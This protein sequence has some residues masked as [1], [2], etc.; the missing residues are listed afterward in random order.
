MCVCG[1]GGGGGDGGS[2]SV[3]LACSCPIREMAV[4]RLIWTLG[5]LDTKSE[6]KCHDEDFFSP[7]YIF[8][9]LWLFV[10]FCFL[11]VKIVGIRYFWEI[12]CF[13]SMM[14]S[15]CRCVSVSVYYD[16]CLYTD[17]VPV[18]IVHVVPLGMVIVWRH[19]HEIGE[20]R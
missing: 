1:G 2:F 18:V 7:G 9:F 5:H 16:G 12:C 13:G 19:G 20:D 4:I 3:S 6:A 15:M 14:V 10:L 11:S 17:A 8:L